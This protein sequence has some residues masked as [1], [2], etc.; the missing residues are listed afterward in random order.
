MT[1]KHRLQKL[2]NESVSVARG[3]PRPL[4]ATLM[5]GGANFALF[6][7][8]ATGVQ[9][10]FFS[11]PRASKPSFTIELDP[12]RNR[13]GDVW[14]IWVSGVRP[15]QSYAYR[16]EGPYKPELGLRFA[17]H[18]FLVDPCATALS[19]VSS[20]DFDLAVV[21]EAR[22]R[23]SA[24]KR[25]TAA[26]K[27]AAK[28]VAKS[29]V[30]DHSFDWGG[31]SS[32]RHPWSETLIYETHVRGLTIHPSSGVE[33]PGTYR[34]M[35]EK[36]PHLKQLGVTA[37]ELLPV[38]EFNENEMKRMDPATGRRLCNYWGYSPVSFFA[39]K[40][41]YASR[42]GVGSQVVEFKEMVR[43]FHQSGIEVILD[44]VFNHTAE[45]DEYGP[46]IS[47]RGLDN[48][49]YYMLGED[50]RRYRDFSGCL[51]TVNCNQPHVTEMILACLRHW[52]SEMHVDGFRFDLASIL[53]RDE[54]GILSGDTPLLKR[55]EAD[56]IL[57]DVKLIAEP[58]DAGWAFQVGSFP[59]RLWA[60][61][62]S[63]Y[64]DD[65]RRFWRGDPGMRGRLATR[66]CGSSDLYQG[67]GKL[68]HNSIN[69][70]TCHDGF[71]LNDL[72]SYNEKHNLPNAH[73]NN[74]GSDINFSY[75][76]GIEGE[77]RDLAIETVRLQQIKNL[78]AT[79]LLS[80]GVPM[81]LGGDEFR[82]T[83]H[84][85]NNAYCQDNEVSWY[86][87]RLTKL[88]RALLRFTCEMISF[89]RRYKMLSSDQFYTDQEVIWFDPC[90]AV[91]DWN[92]W[93]RTLGC[94]IRTAASDIQ[95]LCT[96]FNAEVHCVDFR[97]PEVGYYSWNLAI[98]TAANSPHD[99][100]KPGRLGPAMDPQR[101]HVKSRS[102]IVLV[103]SG[104]TR[105]RSRS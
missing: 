42:H 26:A 21:D 11:T 15:G 16:V 95:G 101:V 38:Q 63:L 45:R 29:V 103:G 96:L 10:Q 72:V 48:P 3:K 75:N 97:L 43:A 62:N 34:G 52:V 102:L 19:G 36:I 91:P 22:L 35:V 6:T 71:T 84:G 67:S 5:S 83:Q 50:K 70:I 69:F 57:R 49:V 1:S 86:D 76:H 79:L 32:P 25:L 18:L 41:S 44:V 28:S 93:D 9:L 73:D 89:R 47:F 40:E 39:P 87:W 100:Y 81:L 46:T 53:A 54:A 85:N 68:P 27:S 33:H 20:W 80:R 59:G 90:G 23:S 98:D 99:I 55:I 94:V 78:L 14:H 58:W 60:E 30:V 17:P 65:V 61:W 7:R 64:R 56:P 12:Y 77:S 92:A 66:L 82:R 88:N 104:R 74:D 4:G 51:N 105:H 31:V 2:Q 24:F 8:D 13:T 37:V